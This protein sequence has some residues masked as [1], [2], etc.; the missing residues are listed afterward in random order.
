M[1]RRDLL[2]YSLSG[3]T[4]G[5]GSLL[6][7]Q[8]V[9]AQQTQNASSSAI[10][11]SGNA[12][13]NGFDASQVIEAARNLAKK[14]FKAPA[15]PLPDALASLSYEQYS[16]IRRR[17]EARLWAEDSSG[18]ALE[19]LHR[20]FI[21]T[22]PVDIHLVDNGHV[23]KLAYSPRDYDFGGLKIAPDTPDIGFSGLRLSKTAGDQPAFDFALFQGAS[24]FRAVARGQVY[25]DMARGLSVRTADPRGEE[26][27]IFRSFWIERPNIAS[28]AIVLHALLDSES[29]T[30]AYRFT[31]R[32][33]EATIIDT[34]MTL[35]A[36]VAIDR[37]GIGAMTG[38]HLMSALDHRRFDD[39]RPAVYDAEG[40]QI[41]NGRGEWLWRPV[42]NRETLQ[43]SAFID[44]NPRGFGFL[45]RSRDGGLFQDD[46]NRWE[47]HPSLWIEPI[48]DW[49]AGLI[50]LVEIPNEADIN[51]NIVAYWQPQKQLEAGSETSFAFRQFW[52]WSPPSKPPYAIVTQSRS[53]RSASAPSNGRKRRFLVEFQGD[54]L[55][56][57]ESAKD[58]TPDLSASN[59]SLSNQKVY[60]SR[61]AK[62]YRFVFD[63]EMG[64]DA[65]S[66]LRLQL[67]AQGKPMS[68]IWL[69]R[70]T[71]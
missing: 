38:T 27:P 2:T 31:L 1:R 30:G 22:Q 13:N 70:W 15:S 47:R 67:Q 49:G 55:G 25:G 24:F 42:T 39:I 5:A 48:G 33:S 32:T 44:E 18:F 66:E 40:L 52:C 9:S 26:F 51:Q 62:R 53:G 19:P 35:F 28:D 12:G 58:I 41:A 20:G 14:P 64:N 11:P 36:R 61:E 46:D 10:K 50:V 59:A 43:I 6:L 37:F 8:Q 56:D 45:Q 60:F 21:Y 4:M 34:E 63:M 54:V 23:T 29:V 16:A 71:P 3:L 7:A 65:L 68:E 69:Y 17:P 57:L